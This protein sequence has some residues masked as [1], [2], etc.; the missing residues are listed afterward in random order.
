MLRDAIGTSDLDT[1]GRGSGISW[2]VDTG[3]RKLHD[4]EGWSLRTELELGETEDSHLLV[5]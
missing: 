3:Q 2:Q 4:T 1:H 5:S